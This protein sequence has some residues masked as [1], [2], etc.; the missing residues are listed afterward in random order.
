MNTGVFKV[1]FAYADGLAALKGDSCG[2]DGLPVLSKWG[3]ATK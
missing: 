1:S 2:V 3:W